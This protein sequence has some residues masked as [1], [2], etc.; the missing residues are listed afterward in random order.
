M[1]KIKRKTLTIRESLFTC[2]PYSLD[3][4]L[5][6]SLKEMQDIVSGYIEK[7]GESAKLDW[8]SVGGTY[9]EDVDEINLVIEYQREE[10]QEEAEARVAKARKARETRKR[11]KELRE[12]ELRE[13][14]L[15]E[16]ERLRKKYG[17]A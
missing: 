14:E 12:K 8:D 4:Y 13:K 6:G 3:C 7:Y 1:S 11:N 15:A 16:L 2:S 9:Y 10:T 5:G 17:E